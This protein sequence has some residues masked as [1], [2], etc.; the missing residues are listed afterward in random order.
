MTDVVPSGANGR[1][2]APVPCPRRSGGTLPLLGQVA[3]EPAKYEPEQLS[4]SESALI[5]RATRAADESLASAYTTIREAADQLVRAWHD[6]GAALQ[7]LAGL[8]SERRLAEAGRRRREVLDD[9]RHDGPEDRRSRPWWLAAPVVWGMILASALY[10]SYFFA[11]TFQDALDL[12]ENPSLWETMVSY[13]PGVGIAIALI[14]SGT[15]LASPWFRHR[16][17]AERRPERG[18]LSWRIVF[19]RVFR[20]WRPDTQTRSETDLPW[21]SWPLPVFFVLMVSGVLGY[22]AWLRGQGI[23]DDSL[24]WPLVALLLLL[25]MSAIAL[26]AMSHNPFADRER[27]SRRGLESATARR[28]TLEAAARTE[29]ARCSAAWYHLEATTEEAAAAARRCLTEAWAQIAEERERHQRAGAIAPDFAT[30]APDADML[31]GAQFYA[32]LANPRLRVY[33]LEQGRRVLDEHQVIVLEKRLDGLLG[34]LNQQ[35]D[36]ALREGGGP[37]T[38]RP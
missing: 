38:S 27:A 19:N 1:R 10:D 29:V 11:T 13:V 5:N 7:R 33:V 16:V 17:R 2:Y 20:V 12:E 18:P 34:E 15:L 21:P 25:T 28:G 36:A 24:Q 31:A 26:K 4:Y 22:W 6:A 37:G 35:L 9:H 23:R 30:G 3:A 8:R 14:I 32:G